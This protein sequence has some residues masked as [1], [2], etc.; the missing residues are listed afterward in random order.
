MMIK[1]ILKDLSELI[2]YRQVLL[3]LT[4]QQLILR[5]RRTIFGYF[6]TLFNPILMMSVTAVVFS[7]L[8]DLDL[9][10]YAIFLFAGMIPFNLFSASITQTSGVFLA[11][12][13]ILKKIYIPKMLFPVSVTLSVTIDSLLSFVVLMFILLIV[14]AKISLPLIT[15]PFA[16]F[17]LALFS[18]G[19]SL[20]FSVITV[21]FRDLQ[22]IVV[23]VLQALF[24]LSPVIYDKKMLYGKLDWLMDLNPMSYYIDLF[25]EP[26]YLA[27]WPGLNVVFISVLITAASLFF[28]LLFFNFQQK[29]IIYRL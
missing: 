24:F 4:R 27:D 19:L 7:K 15:I 18:F 25:R 23:I 29:K 17:L 3:Q 8:F 13:S 26:I 9:G 11:N 12:E 1:N 6:W 16:F 5:Y 20:I 2:E 14:G 28:G 22:H 21:F 10:T